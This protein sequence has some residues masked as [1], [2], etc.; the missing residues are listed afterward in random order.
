MEQLELKCLAC[1]HKATEHAGIKCLWGAGTYEPNT[2]N[3]VFRAGLMQI[4]MHRLTGA[5]AL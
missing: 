3:A 4:L 5:T 1:K 2:S